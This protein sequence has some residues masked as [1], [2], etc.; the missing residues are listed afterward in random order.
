MKLVEEGESCAANQPR[1]DSADARA[2][3]RQALAD[4][5]ALL[6]VRQHRRLRSSKL[7]SA[8]ADKPIDSQCGS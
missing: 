4:D 2:K 1:D 8:Q 3:Q 5:I 7:F 6:V